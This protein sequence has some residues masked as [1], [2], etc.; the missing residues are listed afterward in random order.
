MEMIPGIFER[1]NESLVCRGVK[2]ERSPS[3]IYA[4]MKARQQRTSNTD[5]RQILLI[6]PFSS[7]PL[8]HS[9][10]SS[11]SSFQR[12]LILALFSRHVD[13]SL[14][15][16]P[17]KTRGSYWLVLETSLHDRLDLF[18][19]FHQRKV[20][21]GIRALYEK[22]GK[23]GVGELFGFFILYRRLHR[24][25]K[26]WL[27]SWLLFVFDHFSCLLDL[28]VRFCVCVCVDFCC[29]CCFRCCL[30]VC[31]LVCFCR[32]SGLVNCR[33]ALTGYRSLSSYTIGL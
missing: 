9:A 21:S 32:L 15:S 14:G 23:Y 3:G 29:C 27:V 6:L 28:C 22:S 10:V 4:V 24:G 19:S 33:I 13:L 30:F 25:F 16:W 31:F 17:V 8:S 5:G 2:G 1:M 12:C 26:V 20:W 18:R 7:A 11:L